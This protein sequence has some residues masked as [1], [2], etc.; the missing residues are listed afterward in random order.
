MRTGD[1]RKL[2]LRA[3]KIG[4]GSSLAIFLSEFLYLEYAAAAGSVTLLTLLTTKWET[5]RLSVFRLASFAL[6][7]VLAFVVFLHTNDWIA[8]GV[9]IFIIFVISNLLNWSATVS[10]NAVIGTHFLMTK[11]F[12]AAFV[13]NECQLVLIGVGIAI[14]LNLFQANRRHKKE[15]I[16]SM[17]YVEK[18]LQYILGELAAYLTDHEMQRSVWKD[19]QE[20][21]KKLQLYIKEAEEYQDNTFVSHPAYYIDYFNMRLKQCQILQNLHEESRKIRTMPVQAKVIAEYIL[22]LMDYVIEVNAPDAQIEELQKLFDG[23]KRQPLPVTR[24]EFESRAMLFHMLMDIQ[25]FL[26]YKKEF[27]EHLDAVQLKQ[28]WEKGKTGQN[29]ADRREE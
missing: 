15:I 29:N 17:R 12:S 10:V 8:Y 3:L 2:F 28:Y 4:V 20:L 11:D 7:V 24:E 19:L 13:W 9:F 27:V 21:E 14:I 22:Y 5:L 18:Q 1:F 25:D 6:S 26:K 16:D 23:M